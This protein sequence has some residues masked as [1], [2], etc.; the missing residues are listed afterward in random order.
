MDVFD[1]QDLFVRSRAV[2]DTMSLF[3]CCEGPR[4]TRRVDAPKPPVGKTEY[5]PRVGS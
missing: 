2:D 3:P 4:A 1:R 5:G